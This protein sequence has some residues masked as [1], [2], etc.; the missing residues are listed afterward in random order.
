MT[1]ANNSTPI[2]MGHGDSDDVVA[3][4][5]GVESQKALKEK[6]FANLEFKTYKGMGHSSC[7]EEMRDLT[8]FLGRILK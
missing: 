1:D 2:F 7:D 5:W 4:K 3:Y 6:G 8:V